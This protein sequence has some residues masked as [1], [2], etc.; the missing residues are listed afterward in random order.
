MKKIL[1]ISLLFLGCKEKEE[2]TPELLNYDVNYTMVYSGNTPT[3]T[4]KDFITLNKVDNKTYTV[5][6]TIKTLNL[7]ATSL[8]KVNQGT[9]YKITGDGSHYLSKEKIKWEG[10]MTL[11]NT[12][13]IV[14][15]KSNIGSQTATLVLAN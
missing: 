7:T 1:L 3:E 13:I 14:S 12:K 4:G 8:G 5:T 11:E 9:L 10:S 6:N 15:A 2:V